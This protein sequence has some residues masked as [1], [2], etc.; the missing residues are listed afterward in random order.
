[1]S[2]NIRGTAD[3]VTE[4]I[5][6]ALGPYVAAHPT[7]EAE[8][9]RYSPVSVRARIIDPD[10]RGKSRSERHKTV[11]PLLYPLN[12]DV[13]GDLTMLLLLAPEERDTSVANR[14][15]DTGAYAKA[16]ATALKASRGDGSAA[17]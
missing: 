9:Y 2:V 6:A 7:A 13:L 4:A 5:A 3:P 12:E 16:Y 14:D 17:P 15:F 8:V 11:W 1:M 10:F